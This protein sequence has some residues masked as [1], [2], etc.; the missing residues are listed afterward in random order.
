MTKSE[1]LSDINSTI[2]QIREC[3]RNVSDDLDASYVANSVE[4]WLDQ[5]RREVEA[6]EDAEGDE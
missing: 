2:D 6:Y 5:L 3:C 4:M 1:A